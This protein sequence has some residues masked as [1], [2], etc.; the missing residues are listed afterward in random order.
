MYVLLYV[1]FQEMYIIIF[2]GVV[3]YDFQVGGAI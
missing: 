1:F 3:W 2:M